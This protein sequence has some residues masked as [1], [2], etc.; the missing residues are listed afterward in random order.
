MK[1]KFLTFKYPKT[2]CALM[3]LNI[4]F[5]RYLKTCSRW[6]ENRQRNRDYGYQRYHGKNYRQNAHSPQEKQTL[7]YR[8]RYR[9][10]Y[11]RRHERSYSPLVRRYR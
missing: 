9:Q 6:L 11:H 7:S 5:I 3:T 4:L 1:K 8:Q 10:K 2:Q